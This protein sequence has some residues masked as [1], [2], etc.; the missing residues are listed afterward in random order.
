MKKLFLVLSIFLFVQ[1]LGVAQSVQFKGK[2]VNGKN[3]AVVEGANVLIRK[4]NLGTT[5]NHGGI[6]QFN[7]LKQGRYRMQISFV[8]FENISQVVEVKDGVNVKV[9]KLKPS[10][11]QFEDVV[12]QAKTVR[13]TENA[14]MFEVPLK[15]IPISTASVSSDLLEQTQANSVA[16]ALA[17]TSGI[18][19]VVNYGGFQTFTMRGFGA[20]VIMLDGARDERMNF[21]NS[22]PLTSLASVERIEYVK[23]PASVLYGHTAVGGIVNVVRKSADKDFNLQ[24]KATYGSR[25][26][27]NF[28][29]GVGDRLNDRLSYR[30]DAAT[31]GGKGWRNTNDNGINGY[32]ALD[33]QLNENNKF[34]LK[35][36]ANK[37][38]YGTETGLPSVKNDIYNA[39]GKLV[40][41]KGELPANFDIEQRYNDPSDYLKH[42][43]ANVD[44]NYIHKMQNGGKLKVHATYTDDLIDYF[45]TEELSYLTSKSPIYDHYYMNG[46]EKTYIG[47]DSLKRTFPLRFSHETN[48]FQGDVKYAQDYNWGGMKHQLNMGYTFTAVD[49]VSYSGYSLGS[50]VTG[51]GLKA[52]IAIV[53]P[54]LNQ[55]A[56]NTKFSK[57]KIYNENVHGFYFHDL[58]HISDKVKALAGLRFDRFDMEYQ[59]AKIST[60]RNKTDKTVA[61]SIVNNA[62][63]YR[64]GVVYEPLQNLSF[65]SSYA[66]FFKPKR[67][68]YNDTYIYLNSDG[69]EFTPEDGKEVFEPEDGHQL[70]LGGK[71][72]LAGKLFVNGSVYYIKKN[73]IVEYLGKNDAGNRIYGQVGVVDSK[74]FDID[75]TYL[76]LENWKITAG[77]GFNAAEYKKFSANKYTSSKKGNAMRNNP[78]NQFFF[79]SNYNVVKGLLKNVSVGIGARYTDKMYTNSSNSYE[80]DSYTLVDANVSYK[81]NKTRFGI[82]VNNLLDKTHFVSS[83]YS[84][85]YIPGPKRNVMFSV[86]VD[87][88]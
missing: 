25:E 79:W 23:G 60:G 53:D 2:V 10:K 88:K 11:K 58:I 63:T 36:G 31:Y 1:Y 24:A 87:L 33:Y 7:D 55:G 64:L 13:K 21:S 83:V 26:K 37:D 50:D 67:T 75:V 56:L 35:L 32:L 38:H 29:F 49:R 57:A 78:E 16:E 22:A 85:Q 73:N 81:I 28:E 82:K 59:T 8:G 17:Y 6:F 42:E 43:N 71:Y 3:G 39:Q 34:E 40:Y 54:V 9:F 74:G 20:P 5:T 45:S 62:L 68:V 84:S 18:K 80:L 70:E 44:L 72:E 76:P 12:V 47:L 48:T 14:L 69:N 27:K 61:K 77:Y 66:T 65:Y 41:K 46:D 52:T 4:V 51:A 19:P 86:S 30:F 15:H